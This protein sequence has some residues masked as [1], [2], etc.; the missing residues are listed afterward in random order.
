[1]IKIE[2]NID[3][4]GNFSVKKYKSK[5]TTTLEHIDIIMIMY[6]EIKDNVPDF[7]KEK[8]FQLV[9]IFDK[10]LEEEKK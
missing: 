5:N 9:E 3:K 1:M 6:Q 2:T 8:L 7:T 10:Q 4:N